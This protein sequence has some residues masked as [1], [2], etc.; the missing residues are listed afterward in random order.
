[1]TITLVDFKLG[2]ASIEGTKV[3]TNLSS[4]GNIK[5]S[6]KVTGG[7]VTFPNG[8]G[9]TYEK[10]KY[11]TQIAGGATDEIADDIYSIEGQAKTTFK[12]GVVVAINTTDALI[13]KVSCA[14]ISAGTLQVKVG[15]YE[16]SLNYSVPNNGECDNKALLKWN[17]KEQIILLP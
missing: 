13:K 1:M 7:K 17:T 9:Y 10:L 4:N 12:N 15:Q 8:R 16:F 2:R 5:F 3:I 14:W 11:V 6:V